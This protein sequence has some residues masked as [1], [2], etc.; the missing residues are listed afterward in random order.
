MQI[1][2]AF[3]IIRQGT[4]FSGGAL[5]CQI[6][7]SLFAL[8]SFL[9]GQDIAPTIS[10]FQQKYSSV[11]TI[12]GSFEQT[13]K[14][15]GITQVESG[16]FRMKKSGLMRWEYHKPEEKLFIADGRETSLYEPDARQV[17]IQP[18]NAADL[19]N[20]PFRFL[21]GE[22]EITKAYSVSWE[23]IIKPK[24]ENTLLL[25]LTPL[26]KEG[27]YSFIVLELDKAGFD[28]RRIVLREQGGNT[29][30]FLFSNIVINKVFDAKLFTFKKPKGVEVLRMDEGN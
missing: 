16:E 25:R 20:T 24:L 19:R 30:E 11:H 29:H 26:D 21:F 2:A 23:S 15:P 7:I 13:Y 27:D 14:A 18:Y 4:R 5:T 12:A 28:I 22:E 3:R 17:S 10:G 8:L 6:L 9:F 1:N